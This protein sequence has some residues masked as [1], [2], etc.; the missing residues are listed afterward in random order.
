MAPARSPASTPLLALDVAHVRPYTDGGAHALPNGL[1]MRADSHRLVRR[2]LRHRHARLHRS[3]RN[4]SPRVL[5]SVSARRS[6][7]VR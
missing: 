7:R 5:T 1:L 6:V 4:G 3:A 2:R